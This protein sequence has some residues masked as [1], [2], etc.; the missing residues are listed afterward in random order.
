M[1]KPTIYQVLKEKLGREPSNTELN[2]EVKR[3][4]KEGA[5]EDLQRRAAKGTLPHQR[6]KIRF[7]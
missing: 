5:E 1:R 6:G 4:L 3:I 7:L 2:V